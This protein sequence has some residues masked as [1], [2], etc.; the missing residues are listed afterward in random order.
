VPVLLTQPE[1]EEL[2][3]WKDNA[4]TVASFDMPIHRPRFQELLQM[5]ERGEELGKGQRPRYHLVSDGGPG[6]WGA[7]LAS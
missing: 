5:W 2:V 3:F 4:V 6:D 1:R 7:T